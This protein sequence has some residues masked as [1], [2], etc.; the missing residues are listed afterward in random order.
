MTHEKFQQKVKAIPDKELIEIASLAISKLCKTGAKSFTMT[1]PPQLHDTDIILSEIV[2]R[3]QISSNFS[4][5]NYSEI[6]FKDL[7]KV[8]FIYDKINDL[9]C[10]TDSI[11]EDIIDFM[12]KPFEH[13]LKHHGVNISETDF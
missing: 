2:N 12:L 3:F 8:S 5:K 4:L 13:I 11:H 6:D 9:I 10:G 1:V 7:Q